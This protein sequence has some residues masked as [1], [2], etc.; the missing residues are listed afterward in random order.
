MR[1][2][3]LGIDIVSNLRIQKIEQKFGEKFLKKAFHPT[4]IAEY[5]AIKWK[6]PSKAREFLGSR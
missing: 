5:Q 3:G 4:E 6:E 2:I 1:I